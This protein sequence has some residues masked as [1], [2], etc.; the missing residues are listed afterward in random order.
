MAD[1]NSTRTAADDDDFAALLA[2]SSMASRR[3]HH[4]PGDAV[5]GTV[6]HIGDKTAALDLDDGQEALLDLTGLRGR[7]GAL[8]IHPGDV[9]S[10]Q[11][12]RIRDRVV[13]VARQL[14]KSSVNLHTLEE[15]AASGLPVTGTIS[16]TNKGGYVVDLGHGAQGFC[17]HAMI[18]VRR[19]EDGT[20]L[21]GT[22]SQFKVIEVRGSKD[23]LLS[24]RAALEEAQARRAEE[25]R[26]TI[27]VGARLTGVVT[28][29]RDFGAFVDLG[30]LEGLIPASELA[31]GRVRVHDVVQQGDKV[32]VVVQRVEP[33]LDHRGRPVE[34]ISLSMRAL[35]PDPFA[36]LAPDLVAGLLVEGTV[37]RVEPFGAFVELIPGVLGLI[38]VG[39][40][41]R[42]IGV[43]GEV[44]QPEQRVTVRVLGVD[45][46]MRR[47][48]L[49]W[50][51]PD[52]LALTRDP[53][54]ATPHTATAAR[55]VGMAKPDPRDRLSRAGADG[56]ALA[57]TNAP[58]EK[59]RPPAL[60]DV[61][62]CTVDRVEVFGVL[63]SWG[64]PGALSRGLVAASELGLAQGADLRRHVPV[65]TAF[66]AVVT[67]VRPDGRIRLSKAQAEL[68]DEQAQARA[69]LASQASQAARSGVGT[70]GELLLSRLGAKK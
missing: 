12:V 40:F 13:E 66:R 23:V 3:V 30:G 21:I 46:A 54:A 33:A 61:V 63:V 45:L 36:Q 60:G 10:G 42:R 41:G 17:P 48:S 32:D 57:P 8:T 68:A 35:A 25:T 1:P 28:N 20:A 27:V 2:E 5:R 16:A 67:E 58:A 9:V 7:D 47:V 29:V 6:R 62:D 65:G 37:R 18:D 15:A 50:C 52:K 51:D 39:A 59:P 14:G 53:D 22:S 56:L 64:Q 70:F 69:F 38:H 19:I 49:A 26:A 55:F 11:V 4:K 43:P 31:H 24:R 34:R 44:V